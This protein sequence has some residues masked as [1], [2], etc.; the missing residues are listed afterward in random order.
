MFFRGTFQLIFCKRLSMSRLL[1][2]GWKVPAGLRFLDCARND[3]KRSHGRS[4]G[5]T[6][7]LPQA[8]DGAVA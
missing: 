1:H 6:V 7:I 5:M 4:R 8:L 2:G 3:N